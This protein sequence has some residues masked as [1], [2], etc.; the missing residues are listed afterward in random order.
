MLW[1]FYLG[2]GM[3]VAIDLGLGLANPYRLIIFAILILPGVAWLAYLIFHML[4]AF[5][6][7]NIRQH[8]QDQSDSHDRPI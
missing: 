4:K 1:P 7:W 5:R 2:A 8:A 6:L 3:S